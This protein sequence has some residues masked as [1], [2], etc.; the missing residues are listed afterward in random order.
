MRARLRKSM[1]VSLDDVPKVA[2]DRAFMHA[3]DALS[4]AAIRAGCTFYA[5]YPITP[6]TEILEYM[7]L[8]LP[9][10]GGTFIQCEQEIAGISMVYGAAIAGSRAM[11]SSSSTAVSLMQETL[12][13]AAALEVPFVLVNMARGGPG[14]GNLGPSQGDY[15]QSTRGGGHGGYRMPVLG[16]ATTQEAADLTM[17]A[18]DLADRWR[19]PVTILGDAALA[20]TKE[21]VTFS[22]PPSRDGLP[23]KDW[24]LTGAD[25]RPPRRLGLESLV[26]PSEQARHNQHLL[27][28][29]AAIEEKEVRWE[30]VGLEDELDVLLIAYGTPARTARS[31]LKELRSQG[32]RIGLLRP[33]TLW[34]FPSRAIQAALDATGARRVAVLELSAG[35]MVEDVRLAVEGRVPV[36]LYPYV[37]GTMPSASQVEGHLK[38][39]LDATDSSPSKVRS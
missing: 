30:G 9:Q 5:G 19:T 29:W 39:S 11:I 25:G 31:P 36:D 3:N 17:L 21:T 32:Q 23:A 6:H 20:T 37:G 16:P 13:L 14:L 18:F 27:D 4:E 8:G 34:P 28:K 2:P 15:F 38:E 33:I 12:S 1:S 35:Q 22:N 10:V 7:A 26:D 24:I